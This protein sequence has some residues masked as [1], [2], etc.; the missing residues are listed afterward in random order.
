ML[1]MDG[2]GSSEK[3]SLH[4]IPFQDILK[5][6]LLITREV[7]E[8]MG[9]G[10]VVVDERTNSLILSDIPSS[11]DKMIQLVESLDVPQPQVEI[12]ARIVQTTKDF[13]KALGIK[14][15][16]DARAEGIRELG[17]TRTVLVA[18]QLLRVPPS[19][20][21]RALQVPAGFDV[22]AGR[23][24]REGD[25]PAERHGHGKGLKARRQGP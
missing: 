22:A 21:I 13:A 16:M 9:R 25:S 23:P 8:A 2:I 3:N 17:K 20:H 18:N 6:P 1:G 11:V 19:P 10:T 15:G 7:V 24:A 5:A 4:I 12:E 14:W